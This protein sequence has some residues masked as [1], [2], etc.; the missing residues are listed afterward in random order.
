MHQ[1][2][3]LFMLMCETKVDCCNPCIHRHPKAEVEVEV[4]FQM[5]S[6][7]LPFHIFFSIGCGLQETRT[8]FGS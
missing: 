3:G 5:Q 4:G 8:C 6:I 1:S 7:V 2:I